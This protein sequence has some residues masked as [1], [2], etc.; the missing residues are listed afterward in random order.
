MARNNTL[1]FKQ[2]LSGIFKIYRFLISPLFG[3]AC[4]FYPSCSIYCE[5]A[6]QSYGILAGIFLAAK[7]LLKCH[8]FHRG[9]YDPLPVLKQGRKTNEL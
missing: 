3:N 4:R 9:G 8:P 5:E 6:I 2:I 7:R 1:L